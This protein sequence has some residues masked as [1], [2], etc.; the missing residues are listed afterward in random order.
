LS[1]P[2]PSD[3]KRDSRCQCMAFRLLFEPALTFEIYV[4]VSESVKYS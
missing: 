3:A 4:E 2:P 1:A